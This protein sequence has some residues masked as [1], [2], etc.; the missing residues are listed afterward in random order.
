MST[1]A[2][3]S[4]KKDMCLRIGVTGEKESGKTT[5]IYRMCNAYVDFV[6]LS[7]NEKQKI[8]EAKRGLTIFLKI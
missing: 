6:S 2:A 8:I 5:L 4:S 1:S 3:S 7:E